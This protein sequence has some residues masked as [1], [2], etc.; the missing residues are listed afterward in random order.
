[1]KYFTR[2]HITSHGNA[3]LTPQKESSILFEPDRNRSRRGAENAG[4]GRQND[5]RHR[6]VGEAPQ[7]PCFT[8]TAGIWLVLVIH[9]GNVPG[10]LLLS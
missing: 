5:T 10:A 8:S 9:V 3:A 1:M 6:T 4:I 2:R 7:M